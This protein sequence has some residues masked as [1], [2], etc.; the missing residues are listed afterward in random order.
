MCIILHK[1]SYHET[2]SLYVSQIVWLV[3]KSCRSSFRNFD[4]TL[5]NKTWFLL[6][7]D[8]KL[9]LLFLSNTL[10]L[11]LQWPTYYHPPPPQRSCVNSHMTV[12]HHTLDLTTDGPLPDMGPHCPYWFK[13]HFRLKFWE[14]PKFRESVKS[15]EHEIDTFW[16]FSVLLVTRWFER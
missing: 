15:L 13:V 12:N 5:S 2:Y 7:N 14:F 6:N 1:I 4:A 8:L 11:T 9:R 10:A 3:R 16:R